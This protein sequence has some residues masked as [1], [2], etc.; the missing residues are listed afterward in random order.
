M[1]RS[2]QDPQTLDLA[3]FG[4]DLDSC[5]LGFCISLLTYTG[6]EVICFN[7][8]WPQCTQ[9]DCSLSI[10]ISFDLSFVSVTHWLLISR[11]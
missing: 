1:F 7:S 9:R 10:K 5:S 11:L 6:K 8:F 4:L 3:G 2:G